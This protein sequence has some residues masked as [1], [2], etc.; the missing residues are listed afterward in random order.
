MSKKNNK[1]AESDI[2]VLLGVPSRTL[3]DWKKTNHSNWRY[4]I[5]NLLKNHTYEELETFVNLLEEKKEK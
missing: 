5:Y 4:K 2:T 1:L 3:Q